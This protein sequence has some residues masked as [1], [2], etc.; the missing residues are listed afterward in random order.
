[1][2]KIIRFLGFI[3]LL[4]LLFLHFPIF[5][6]GTITREHLVSIMY[7]KVSNKETYNAYHLTNHKIEKIQ[8]CGKEFIIHHGI[9]FPRKNH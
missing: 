9:F 1:M 8:E 6:I 5:D 7:E 4:E 2:E 3:V